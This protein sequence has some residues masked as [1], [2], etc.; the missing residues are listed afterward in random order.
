MITV[1][2]NYNES[3]FDCYRGQSLADAVSNMVLESHNVMNELMMDILL[4]EP[5]Y[6]Y[7]LSIKFVA[8]LL[9]HGITSFLGF[10]IRLKIL[11]QISRSLVL[12]RRNMM[13]LLRL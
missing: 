4:T 12:I 3:A 1:I 10:L 7:E 5:S 11:Q 2:D 13:K 8:L 6:L 9:V